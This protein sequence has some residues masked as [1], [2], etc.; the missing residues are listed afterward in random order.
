MRI[1]PVLLGRSEPACLLVLACVCCFARGLGAVAV[2]AEELE[3][4]E[5]VVVAGFD[6]VDF[7]FTRASG[8]LLVAVL[9]G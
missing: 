5:V 9:A 3:V 8:Q 6:V 2:V 1:A 7:A 4:G